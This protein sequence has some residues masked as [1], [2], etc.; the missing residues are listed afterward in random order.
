[1]DRVHEMTWHELRRKKMLEKVWKSSFGKLSV[2]PHQRQGEEKKTPPNP[3][4]FIGGL[5]LFQCC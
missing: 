3:P 5:V 4:G 2:N 1:V